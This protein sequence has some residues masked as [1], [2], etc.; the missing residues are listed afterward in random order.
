MPQYPGCGYVTFCTRQDLPWVLYARNTTPGTSGSSATRLYP[1]PKLM[2]VLLSNNRFPSRTKEGGN[3]ERIRH[4]RNIIIDLG[5]VTCIFV[6]KF[7]VRYPTSSGLTDK[8]VTVNSCRGMVSISSII[9]KARPG[10]DGRYFWYDTYQSY[11]SGTHKRWRQICCSLVVLYTAAT[12]T[13]A[14]VNLNNDLA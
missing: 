3:W 10:G 6:T 11:I 2:E 13:L 14:L 9:F 5:C 7:V 12:S 1:Y 4:S 8:L